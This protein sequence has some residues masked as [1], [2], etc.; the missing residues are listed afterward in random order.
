MAFWSWHA[1]QRA[2]KTAADIFRGLRTVELF[3]GCL[4]AANQPLLSISKGF[5]QLIAL[6]C[7]IDE[8]LCG[9]AC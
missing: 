3:L 5:I 4:P 2:C 1:M 6:L 7:C 9:Y 8:L